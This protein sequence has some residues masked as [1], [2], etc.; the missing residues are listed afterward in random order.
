[1]ALI[2]RASSANASAGGLWGNAYS[3]RVN[4]LNQQDQQAQASTNSLMG[5]IGSVAGMV[6]TKL[7]MLSFLSDENAKEDKR[8][9]K[10]VL[11]ALKKMPVEAWRYKKGRGEG[12][13]QNQHVGAYAQDFKEATGLGDGK[14]ISI[15]DALGVT[16][17]AVKELAE[18]VEAGQGK[19]D[20]DER[21]A[22]KPKPK[23]V[24]R[25]AA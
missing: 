8:E 21:T 11:E 18:K 7:P 3:N 1:M 23:S 25:M 20:G 17:G 5:G 2:Q 9:V 22:R 14:S 6:A 12:G 13:E 24:M 10:G 15:I 19:S 4:L 16:M